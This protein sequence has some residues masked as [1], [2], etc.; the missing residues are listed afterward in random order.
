M[1]GHIFGYCN[2]AGGTQYADMRRSHGVEQPYRIKTWCLGNEMDGEWQIGH[3]T[4]QEY[5]RLA[6]ETARAMR[7]IDERIELVSSGSS[8]PEM[9]T[10]PQ[11]EAVTLGHT[12]DEVDYVSLHQYLGD[13]TND[14]MDYLAK[15]ITMDRFI[16]SVV[17]TCDYVKAQKRSG[18]TMML[19]FDEWN[20]WYHSVGSDDEEMRQRPWQKTPGIVED[21]YTMADALVF[22]TMAITLLN[23]ADRIKIACLAQLV[24]VIAPVMTQKNGGALWRQT[25]Y[26]PF[27][28]FARWGRGTVLQGMAR[29]PA[30]DSKSFARVPYLESAAVLDEDE[31]Q[32]TIFAVN[33]H[34]DTELTME[35]RLLDFQPFELLEHSAMFD[36]DLNATNGPG[37]ER[38]R[39]RQM[40]VSFARGNQ[41]SLALPPASWNVVR[42]KKAR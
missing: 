15:S 34:P 42:L 16:R 10:F 39:P 12:Y 7:R 36:D 30:Y 29:S 28:Q 18:K 20:I 27:A 19:S 6:C 21:I 9:T 40:P 1:V 35:C 22:G 13:T 25:I 41:F 5:G 14:T 37:C 24:N 8:Y 3:K 32:I 33:R 38:I 23:H 26:W 17:S 11:W 2:I 4:A 31:D